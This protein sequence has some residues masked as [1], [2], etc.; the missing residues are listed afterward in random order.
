MG[1]IG[2]EDFRFSC[3]CKCTVVAG[4]YCGIL[5]Y[6]KISCFWVRWLCCAWWGGRVGGRYNIDYEREMGE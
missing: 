6:V 3:W 5:C 2:T 1:G 4:R